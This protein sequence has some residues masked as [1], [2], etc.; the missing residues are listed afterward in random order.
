MSEAADVSPVVLVVDD[1]P[2]VGQMLQLWLARQGT[3]LLGVLVLDHVFGKHEVIDYAVA[4]MPHSGQPAGAG[5]NSWPHR[6]HLPIL[7]SRKR[8]SAPQ[9]ETV[10]AHMAAM[11]TN[12]GHQ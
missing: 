4:A 11:T 5:P 7:A 3:N 12:N 10:L 1:D 2:A 9:S 8:R 6:P